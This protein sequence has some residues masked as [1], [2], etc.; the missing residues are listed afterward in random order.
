MQR[1]ADRVT[2]IKDGKLVITDSVDHLRESAPR[3]MHLRFSA[4]VDT[5]AFTALDSSPTSGA[6]ATRSRST[7][8]VRS[9]PCSRWRSQQGVVD[10]AAR[11]AD[12]DELFLAYYADGPR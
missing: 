4:P 8:P 11:P 12:L 5:G 10:L 3:V 7:S 9:L 2:I 1:V 6:T